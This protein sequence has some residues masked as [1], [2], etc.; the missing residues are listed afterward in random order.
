[1]SRSSSEQSILLLKVMQFRLE[2][3]DPPR[4]KP[5]FDRGRV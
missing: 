4:A 3:R 2:E 5:Y 1:V